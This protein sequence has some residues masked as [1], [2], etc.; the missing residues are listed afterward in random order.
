M[1]SLFSFRHLLYFK[2]GPAT[3]TWKGRTFYLYVHGS[4]I[5]IAHEG[6][7][8]RSSVSIHGRLTHLKDG[9]DDWAV[10]IPE[11]ELNAALDRC[12]EHVV[13]LEQALLDF[14]KEEE[15]EDD[16]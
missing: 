6:D 3:R 4:K 7:Y 2:Q 10:E 1:I 9:S 12:Y 14:E 5:D 11:D 8:V 16:S 15:P 13:E